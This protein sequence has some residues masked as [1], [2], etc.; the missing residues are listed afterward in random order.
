MQRW[1]RDAGRAARLC[2]HE[3]HGTTSA[4]ATWWLEQTFA[5]LPA[6]DDWLGAARSRP[7]ERHAIPEAPRR[8]AAGALD[9]EARGVLLSETARRSQSLA[10]VE[11]RPAPSGAPE[12]FL[13]NEPAPVT[14]S[15]SHR[16]GRAACADRR[17]PSPALL[18]CDL[19][20]AEPR[21]DAFA[22][23]YF[24][25]E[26]QE[27]VAQASEADRWRLLAAA[28]ERQ[29]KRAQGATR[30]AAPGHAQRG[31]RPAAALFGRRLATPAR[32]VRR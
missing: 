22:T 18:G 7:P 21:S 24:T 1:C 32:R 8:L 10:R 25:A 3:L 27:L 17:T 12:V 6:A 4:Y 13:G 9:G 31:R 19:E 11:I 30:G 16:E 14:I 23:D 2:R 26:E 29:G 28:V 20:I 5:D 15:I